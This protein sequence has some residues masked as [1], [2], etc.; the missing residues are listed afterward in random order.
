[1]GIDLKT[2][3]LILG[4]SHLMQVVVFYHQYKANKNVQGP[5]WWL[6]WSAAEAVGFILILLRNIQLLFPWIIIFQDIIIL[7][8]TIFIYIGMKRFFDKKVN[9]KFIVS[10]LVSFAVLHIFFTLVKNDINVRSL[11]LSIFLSAISFITAFSLYKNKFPSIISTANFNTGL[12]IV[13]G[14][15]FAYR[16]VMLINGNTI[17]DVFSPTFFNYLPYFDALIIGLLWTFGFIIM[18]NQRLSTEILEA[19]THFELIFNTNPDAAVISRLSDG[20]FVECNESYTRL[21]GYTREDMAGRSSLD[22]NIY[23]DPSN[24]LEIVRM[25]KERGSCENYEILF[26]R[27]D[28]GLI[29]ALMSARSLILKGVPHI[30]SVTRDISYRKQIEAE[31]KLKNDQLELVNHEKDKFFSIL[32]HDLKGPLSSFVEVTSIITDEIYTMN[33]EK[34]KEITSFMRS[35]AKNIHTLLENLLEWSL[36]KRGAMKFVPEIINLNNL[37]DECKS[38]LTQSAIEKEIDIVV[39]IPYNTE[40]YADN[41]M[42]DSVIRNLVFN[43]IK[44]TFP[45]GS[46]NISADHLNNN[47]V[48]IKVADTGIGM[49]DN[50]LNN[51]FVLNKNT[52]R[53]GTKG[54]PS[55]GIGLILCRDFIER[56]GGELWVQSDEGKGSVFSFTIPVNRDI[57]ELKVM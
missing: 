26:R 18:M 30:I 57:M 4:I 22:V 2:V 21:S 38:I 12:F 13:H 28:G 55:S 27:K 31:L 51:L 54:E 49:D 48:E 45:K 39:S 3:I 29:T 15:V 9:I 37:V 35:S 14:S 19:K 32:A 44:F 47:F 33:I 52:G 40:V 8:G 10:F 25:L 17:S 56:Q 16:A 53:R 50:L 24:R 7:T 6:M 5:G 41:H 36:L 42:L 46:I 11:V 20:L 34:I 43:A 23:Q 1:M